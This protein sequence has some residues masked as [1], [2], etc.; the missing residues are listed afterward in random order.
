M[1][2][3]RQATLAVVLA[4]V[5]LPPRPLRRRKL[6]HVAVGR[7]VLRE[8]VEQPAEEHRRHLRAARDRAGPVR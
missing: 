3:H 2:M 5:R 1:R 8:N 4:S 6:P 7:F